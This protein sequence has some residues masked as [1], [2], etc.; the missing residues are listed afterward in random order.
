MKWLRKYWAL[1]LFGISI[2]FISSCD[3]V[4]VKTASVTASNQCHIDHPLS[5]I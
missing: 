3:M 2:M 5:E 4:A 1:S